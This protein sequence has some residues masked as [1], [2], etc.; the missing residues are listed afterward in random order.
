[1]Q[2]KRLLADPTAG[3]AAAYAGVFAAIAANV[4]D[5]VFFAVAML[6]GAGHR[7]TWSA[8]AGSATC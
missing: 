6:L 5:A 2:V 1:M 4:A 8:P 7:W 3:L